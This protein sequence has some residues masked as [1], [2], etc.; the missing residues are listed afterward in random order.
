MAK[1]TVDPITRIEGHLKIT[2]DI[3]ENGITQDAKCHGE[4]FRGIE[5]GLEGKDAR[6]AQQ[7]TQRVC[8]VC[9]YAHAEA[10]SLALE[11]AMGIKP[12]KNG[13]LL[14]N[15]IIGTHQV[16]DYI[17]HFYTLCALDFIDV[18]AIVKYEGNNN[19]MNQLKKWVLSELK[20]NEI[21]PAAPF[22][23]RYE[24]AYVEDKNVNITAIQNYL[25][26]IDVM[27]KLHKMVAIYGAK[28]P[29]VV[30]IEAGGVTT[31]PTVDNINQY[32]TY[33][34]EVAPFVTKNYVNDVLT[35]AKAFPEYFK[36]GAGYPNFL[37]HD[38]M[39]D[40]NGENHLFRGGAIID[41]KYTKFDVNKI[42]E[43][44]TFSYYENR[45]NNIF[46]PLNS[47]G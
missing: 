19:G 5:K 34:K 4:M 28:S 24:A 18:T 38:F 43:D 46:K 37:A 16:Q 44:H 2:A 36:I 20:N 45:G 39:P 27:R 30:A 14:K 31:M 22:L 47:E 7:V 26:S 42:T 40:E 17:L 13:Q 35:V 15:L 6:V 25:E 3:D 29:H 41:W 10:A 21:Y 23:P 33:L 1:I 8:G 9:P 12:N 11:M 32:R